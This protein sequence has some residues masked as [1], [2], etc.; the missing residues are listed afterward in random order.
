MGWKCAPQVLGLVRGEPKPGSKHRANGLK[1]AKEAGYERASK[2]ATFDKRRSGLNKYEGYR[3]GKQF[4]TDMTEEAEGYIAKVKSKTKDGKE[5]VYER[6]LRSDAVIGFAM[7]FNPPSEISVHWTFEECDKFFADAEA[8][9]AEIEPRLF[10]REN[11][12][13]R[14]QHWDEGVPPETDPQ[15]PE[16]LDEIDANAHIFGVCKDQDGN[17]CG[18]L[19]DSRLYDRINREFPRLMRERGWT[20]MDDLDVTDWKKAKTDKEYRKERNAKRRKNGRSVNAYI[21]EKLHEKAREMDVMIDEAEDL[22]ATAEVIKSDAEAEADRVI[23]EAKTTAREEARKITEAADAAAKVKAVDAQ[24]KADKMQADAQAVAD[25]IEEDAKTA[26]AQRAQDAEVEYRRRV[27]VADEEAEKIQAEKQAALEQEKRKFDED[28]QVYLAR[29]REQ[30]Q[31][32]HEK[33][34]AE[35]DPLPEGAGEQ[36]VQDR[37]IADFQ[38]WEDAIEAQKAA[39]TESRTQAETAKKAYE[40]A[41]KGYEKEVADIQEEKQGVWGTVMDFLSMVQ[42]E[43]PSE[44]IQKMAGYLRG[45]LKNASENWNTKFA[46]W[47]ARKLAQRRSRVDGIESELYGSLRNDREYK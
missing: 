28:R 18:N 11:V 6:S 33:S 19:I 16:I 3:S 23:A 12:R 14:V 15:S 30:A 29:L 8:C 37:M 43:S 31:R 1:I 13:M 10:R 20:E 4:W 26:A 17:Y 2:S 27:K 39:L 44:T 47:R 9:M 34:G 42:T 24:A 25:K 45:H 7:V 36:A 21:A 40:T 22:V 5:V 32:V 38:R 35:E 46:E 41:K